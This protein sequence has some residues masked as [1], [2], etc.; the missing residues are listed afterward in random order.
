MSDGLDA[1]AYLGGSLGF[2]VVVAALLWGAARLRAALLPGWSGAWARLVEAVM[3][4]AAAIGVAQLL[5]TFQA[6]SRGWVAGGC[7]V[8]GAGMV[9]AGHLCTRSAWGAARR[10]AALTATDGDSGAELDAATSGDATPW[11]RLE[12]G[13]AIAAVALVG[14]QWATHVADAFSRG[15]THPDTLWYHASHAAVLVQSHDFTELPGR[16]DTIQAYHPLNATTVHALVD[17][18]FGTDLL[19]PLVNVGWAALALLAAY[20]IGRRVGGRAQ[21][22]FAV[23]G[24]TL[25]FG[26]PIFAGTQ[27]GQASND[28]AVAA[29]LLAG[30]AIVLRNELDAVAATVG[31]IAAGLAIGTKLTVLVPAAAVTVGVVVIAARARRWASAAGWC[32]GAALFGSYWYVRNWVRAD[33]PLPWFEAELGPLSLPRSVDAEGDSLFSN[34]TNTEGWRR[35]YLPG[36][37]RALGRVWPVVVVLALGLAVLLVVRRRRLERLV[38]V[39]VLVGFGGYV[40]TPRTG[41]FDFTFNI[42]YLS[43]VLFLAFVAAPIALVGTA[44]VVRR[45]AVFVFA[46]LVV[47]DVTV[48]HHERVEAWPTQ[49]RWVAILTGLGVVAAAVLLALG[50]DRLRRPSAVALAAAVVGVVVLAIGWPVQRDFLRN[51]YVDADLPIDDIHAAMRDVRDSDV[52]VFGSLE[53]YPLQGLD[54]SNRVAVG[55]GPTT[56]VDTDPCREWADVVAGKFDYVIYTRADVVVRVAPPESWFATDGVRAVAREGDSVVYELDGPLDP[57]E[58]A[59][60]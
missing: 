17:L 14:A 36:L 54:L 30:V 48:Q 3:V 21:G 41:G 39:V 57:P 56:K 43:P 34:V 6:F 23:L 52:M 37:V 4:L 32:A 27:P 2:V 13:A 45:A 58:C 42:R 16:S 26:L 49:Y 47:I 38:G 29:L 28:I 55:Q 24:A 40:L 51:R 60:S 11:S 10:A 33:N 19:G 12:L 44:A 35:V 53:I 25:V 22:A 18:P 9:L 31:G 46:G 8:V 7:I 5:G 15:M 59:A 1:G 20:C 50:S